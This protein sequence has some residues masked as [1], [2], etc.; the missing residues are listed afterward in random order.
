MSRFP[1]LL[2]AHTFTVA[3]ELFIRWRIFWIPLPSSV[4][5]ERVSS[6][7]DA[8]CGKHKTTDLMSEEWC[9]GF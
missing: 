6:A 8:A 4:V 5:P 7:Q 3:V 2:H 9:C 1:D